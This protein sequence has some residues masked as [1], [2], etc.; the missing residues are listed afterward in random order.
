MTRVGLLVLAAATL[1]IGPAAGQEPTANYETRDLVGWSVR[2]H[3]AFPR[4]EPELASRTLAL[5]EDQLRAIER[6]VP[7]PAVAKLRTIPIWVE[8]DEPHHPCMAYHPSASWLVEHDMNPDKA[9]CVEIADARNFLDWC[10]DQP[11]MVLHELAHGYHH[12][13]VEG[14]FNNP[15]IA[16]AH[17]R[18]EASK[19]YDRVLHI[20]GKERRHYALTNPQEYFAEASEAL[21][22]ANDFYPFVRAELSKHDPEGHALIRRL[23]LLDP[24]TR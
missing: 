22:G 18:A 23:W 8:R 24:P 15:E 21:F 3:R 6:A 5:L 16:E 2:I 12:Q 20:N 7:A 9:R 14:G 11:W 13:V 10:R 17:R 1:L 19:S 4:D